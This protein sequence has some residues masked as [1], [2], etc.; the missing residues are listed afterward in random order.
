MEKYNDTR[1]TLANSLREGLE[2]FHTDINKEVIEEVL[3]A[4][5]YM[6]ETFP[7]DVPALV[8]VYTELFCPWDGRLHRSSI[9]DQNVANSK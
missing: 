8:R 9:C 5:V 2:L 7:A 4:A 6:A 3:R 1:R